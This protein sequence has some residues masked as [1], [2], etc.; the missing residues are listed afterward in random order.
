[1][2]QPLYLRQIVLGLPCFLLI[3]CCGAALW[4]IEK[5]RMVA[6]RRVKLA[7]HEDGR[8]FPCSISFKR[9]AC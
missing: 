3:V 5:K 4:A 8:S 1:M 6:E 2:N 7:S 9:S